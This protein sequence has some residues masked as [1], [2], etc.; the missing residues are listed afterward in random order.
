MID[1]RGLLYTIYIN[2]MR[3]GDECG[4][5]RIVQTTENVSTIKSPLTGL[6][7]ATQGSDGTGKKA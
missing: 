7:L 4:N 6:N 3:K 1:L 5:P 2:R